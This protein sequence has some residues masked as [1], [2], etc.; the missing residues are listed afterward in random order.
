MVVSLVGK[1]GRRAELKQEIGSAHFLEH[2]FFDGTEKRPDAITLNRFLDNY[3]ASRNGLTGTETVEYY[4]KV[5]A[6]KSEIAFDFISDIFFHSN[7]VEIEKEKKIIKEEVS[8]KRDSPGDFLDRTARSLLFSDQAVGRS[9]FDEEDR[10]S[11][12][13]EDMLRAYMRRTYVKENFILVVS[14]NIS[15]NKVLSL[16]E[17]YFSQF[18]SG[19]PVVFQPAYIARDGFVKIFKK[20]FTQSRL[21]IYFHGISFIDKKADFQTLLGII[22]GGSS[23]S[24][25]RERL[26][27]KEHLVYA[28]EAHGEHFSDAGYFEIRANM[29]EVN[30]QRTLNLLFEEIRRL[31]KEGIT[32]EELDRAKNKF[33]SEFLFDIERVHSYADYLGGLMLVKGEIEGVENQIARVRSATKEDIMDV[34][35]FTFSDKPKI[36]LLTKNL[37]SLEVDF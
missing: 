1:V 15:E 29:H 16:A 7:L 13:N 9:I 3:G 23:T 24:R 28:V 21:G 26:R 37:D 35:R 5:L 34:A 36:I 17:K 27:H 6:D 22:L 2:L 18:K 31:M 32:D 4:V 11:V 19:I 33:L 14:G 10:L 8:Q 25:L 20:D 30:A 12:I